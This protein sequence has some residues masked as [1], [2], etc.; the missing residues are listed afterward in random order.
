M[1]HQSLQYHFHQRYRLP[2]IPLKDVVYFAIPLGGGVESSDGAVTYQDIA[3]FLPPEGKYLVDDEI[4]SRDYDEE[5]LIW[6][7][8]VTNLVGDYYIN[9][10]LQ[11]YE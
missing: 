6:I 7:K 2:T 10:K 5:G 11:R 8:S 1:C 9:V 3:I 4:V